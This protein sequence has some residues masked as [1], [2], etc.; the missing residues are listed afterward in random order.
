MNDLHANRFWIGVFAQVAL[1][2]LL[3]VGVAKSAVSG[4]HLL[5]AASLWF[6]A[7]LA[8]NQLGP[9]SFFLSLGRRK[10]AKIALV[11]AFGW[12]LPAFHLRMASP[13]RYR[14]IPDCPPTIIH[15][16]LTD[17]FA[18]ISGF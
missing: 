12:F 18:S 16:N 14:G 10:R 9:S 7:V 1:L 6:V 4:G 13:A 3:A 2:A 8:W 17:S 15:F 5:M 11:F